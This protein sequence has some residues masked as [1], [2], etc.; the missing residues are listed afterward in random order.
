M[1]DWTF[2]LDHG[3]EIDVIYTDFEKAF[4]KV[5]HQALISKLKAYN[6]NNKL[7]LWIQDFCV[8]VNNVY[9]KLMKFIRNGTVTTVL[10]V[11]SH[12][13]GSILGPLRF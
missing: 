8:I 2:N 4:D 10:Q 1:D 12:M 6:L 3:L 13:Q 7:L 9:M 5:L 11:E